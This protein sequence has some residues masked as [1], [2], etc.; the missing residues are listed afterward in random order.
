MIMINIAEYSCNIKGMDLKNIPKKFG[1]AG[2][3]IDKHQ[4]GC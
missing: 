2:M 1:I 4:F 3:R